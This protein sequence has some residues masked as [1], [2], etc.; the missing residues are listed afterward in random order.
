M[1]WANPV[2]LQAQPQLAL[3]RAADHA[4]ASTSST[5]SHPVDKGLQKLANQGNTGPLGMPGSQQLAASK[6]TAA[7]ADPASTAH[8]NYAQPQLTSADKQPQ[9]DSANF[10]QAAKK[11][12][13]QPTGP[14]A[15]ETADCQ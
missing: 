7:P 10:Q 6:P 13:E 15:E 8:V 5:A 14:A 3:D 2:P 12:A 4:H 1:A 9:P 11:A